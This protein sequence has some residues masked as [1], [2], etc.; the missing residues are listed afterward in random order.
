MLYLHVH[1][2]HLQK[3]QSKIKSKKSNV[4][5]VTSLAAELKMAG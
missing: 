3:K 2:L 5:E 1:S 4:S